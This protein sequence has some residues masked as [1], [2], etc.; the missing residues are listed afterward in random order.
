M[1]ILRLHNYNYKDT[2]INKI[3]YCYR[4]IIVSKVYPNF[5][6]IYTNN[7]YGHNNP[8]K[9]IY[10]YI[11]QLGIK[12]ISIHSLKFKYLLRLSEQLHILNEISK[13]KLKQILLGETN[14]D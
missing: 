8:I 11:K 2:A 12:P 7:R 5:I 13:A 4:N 9:Q 6:L 10:I 14:H 3:N 1:R